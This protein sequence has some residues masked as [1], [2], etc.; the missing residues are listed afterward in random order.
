[1][2]R[3]ARSARGEMVNFDL[4]MIA[5]QLASAPTPVEVAARKEFIDDKDVRKKA[6]PPVVADLGVNTLL[7]AADEQGSRVR[8][9][10]ERSAT[11]E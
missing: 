7:A 9:H 2:A 4:L 11:D 3:T 6:A 8:R 5:Q 1:M 10:K